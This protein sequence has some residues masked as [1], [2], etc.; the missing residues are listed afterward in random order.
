MCYYAVIVYSCSFVRYSFP[1]NNCIISQWFKWCLSPVL[2]YHLYT[3]VP[4]LV[5]FIDYLTNVYVRM[6]RKRL[7]VSIFCIN[8][9][10]VF[11]W[12]ILVWWIL[13]NNNN[14]NDSDSDSNSNSNNNR[15]E[16]MLILMC[17]V[18][19]LSR[20]SV[21]TKI[22]RKRFRRCSVLSSL[23]YDYWYISL[24]L[25]LCLSKINTTQE[26]GA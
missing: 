13:K 18:A 21:E 26:R 3:V 1:N 20:E 23:W 9:E 4:R 24:L 14:E 2:A 11:L 22:A 7:R 8:L 10:L 17:C 19:L 15:V 6:N 16:R 25:L 5:K 12:N